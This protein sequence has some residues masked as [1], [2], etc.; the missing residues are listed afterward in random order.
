M[1]TM[2]Y[3][4]R[5]FAADVRQRQQAIASLNDE[6]RANILSREVQSFVRLTPVVRHMIGA[7]NTWTGFKRLREVCRLV[8]DCGSPVD[9]QSSL[10]DFGDIS[11][12]GHRLYWNINCFD[13]TGNF[14]SM[15]PSDPAQTM[16][17][18]VI[19]HTEEG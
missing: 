18:L 4:E 6:M 14:M 3:V 12:N 7:M 8:R 1:L 2:R 15:N 19:G 17:V 13:P 9:C 11:W 10:R 5:E 16:R